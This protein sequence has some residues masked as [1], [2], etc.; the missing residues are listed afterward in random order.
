MLTPQQ[1]EHFRNYGYVPVEK[2]FND[3]EVSAMISE[4]ERFKKQGLGRN[5][6]TDSEAVN[7]QIIPLMDKSP[8]FRALPF[9]DLV[10]ET[11]NQLIGDPVVRVLDQIFLKPGHSGTGTDWHQDNGY[12]EVVDPTK[13]TAMWVAMHD[14]TV[15]NGTLHVVP[16]SHQMELDH[17]RDPGSDHHIHTEVDDSLAVP[18]PLAAGGVV[19]FNYGI[20]HSTRRNNTDKE[21]AGLAY[22]FLNT[23]Y[24]PV[25]HPIP[26]FFPKDLVHLTGAKATGGEQEFGVRVAGTWE[27]EVK[28]LVDAP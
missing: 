24:A 4:L 16:N 23:D 17:G 20:A 8:L 26:K 15:A 7:Y 2:F 1:V 6:A 9:H 21:R 22:H 10:L 27:D 11:V 13:G 5:V 25:T 3:G 19:F 12:F 28:K 14:A 18:I